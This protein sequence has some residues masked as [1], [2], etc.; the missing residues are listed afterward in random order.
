MSK[1]KCFRCHNHTITKPRYSGDCNT[2]NPLNAYLLSKIGYDAY[3]AII[4]NFSGDIAHMFSY[5]VKDGKCI[6]FNN[7]WL[8]TQ[9]SSPEE[10]IRKVYPDKTIREKIPINKWLNDLYAKG[11]HRYWDEEA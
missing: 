3:L 2:V 6:V 4:P 5:G 10:W 8:Y 7:F 1:I 9:F 11:H